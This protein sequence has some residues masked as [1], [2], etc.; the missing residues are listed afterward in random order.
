MGGC[1]DIKKFR[2]IQQ[3]EV[4]KGLKGKKQDLEI[5]MIWSLG[6]CWRKWGMG[7]MKGVMD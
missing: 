4:M 3:S 2:E 6:S 1:V 7:S 5:N